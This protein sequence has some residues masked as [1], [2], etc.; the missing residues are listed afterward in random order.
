MLTFMSSA[1]IYA[2]AVPVNVPEGGS[3]WMYLILA[4][5]ACGVALILRVQS[6][7]AQRK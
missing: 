7:A 6:Q 5:I 3:A 4:S 1:A 2:M